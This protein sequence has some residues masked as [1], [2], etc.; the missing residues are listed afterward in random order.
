MKKKTALGQKLEKLN[1]LLQEYEEIKKW[2]FK[3]ITL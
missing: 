2:N 1:K 3:N